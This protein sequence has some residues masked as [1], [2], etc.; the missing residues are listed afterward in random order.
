MSYQCLWD[1]FGEVRDFWT[2]NRKLLD[3]F[4]NFLKEKAELDRYYG[5]GLEKL[6]KLPLFDRAFGT[7]S[8]IFQGFRTFYLE[9]ASNFLYHA[10]YLQDDLCTQLKKIISAQDAAIHEHKISG[11]RLV[12][13]REKFV[14]NHIKCRNKY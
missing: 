11:K 7:A 1:S 6:G 14:K 4:S 12:F 8:P 9:S 5:K 2:E 10:D 13:E 3:D